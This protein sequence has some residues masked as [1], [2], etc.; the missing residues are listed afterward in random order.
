M[1]QQVM[2]SGH[3]CLEEFSQSS[4]ISVLFMSDTV[5]PHWIFWGTNSSDSLQKKTPMPL[6]LFRC[7][8]TLKDG[9]VL[10]HRSRRPLQQL[11]GRRGEGGLHVSSATGRAWLGG[12]A[13]TTSS[14]AVS[15]VNLEGEG[16]LKRWRSVLSG[17]RIQHRQ[18]FC[19][20]PDFAL[21]QEFDK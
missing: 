13:F 18:Q 10:C 2:H 6:G 19:R 14:V 8:G 20:A 21:V 16:G 17:Q 15:G 12:L 5:I 11:G 7:R 1:S 9:Q 3:C 4:K